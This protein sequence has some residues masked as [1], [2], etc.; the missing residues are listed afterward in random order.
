M[1]TYH[2][3]LAGGIRDQLDALDP[4]RRA[5]VQLWAKRI[6]EIVDAAEPNGWLALALVAAEWTEQNNAVS[7]SES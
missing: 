6:R 5:E 2:L 3:M 7:E 4:A 1:S